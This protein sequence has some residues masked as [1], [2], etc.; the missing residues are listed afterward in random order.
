MYR[1]PYTKGPVVISVGGEYKNYRPNSIVKYH[2]G[3]DLVGQSDKAIVSSVR[4]VAEVNP[5]PESYGYGNHIRIQETGTNRYFLYA[6]LSS[7]VFLSKTEV[8]VG[9]KIGVE[10]N[11]GHSFGSHL[12]LEV[13]LS[14][15]YNDIA[16]PT[17][18]FNFNDFSN[19]LPPVQPEPNA[20]RKAD[21]NPYPEPTRNLKKGDVHEGVKWV[22]WHLQRMGAALIVDGKFEDISDR[23]IRDIQKRNDPPLKADGEVGPLTRNLLACPFIE[24]TVT[25]KQGDK[26][27]GVKWIQWFLNRRGLKPQ[28]IL[29]GEFG[30]Y[31]HGFVVDIQKRYGMVANGI[32]DAKT[33]EKLKVT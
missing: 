9:Q 25:L 8:C 17:K 16:D 27:E 2:R 15:N 13:M 19:V 26:N 31:S 14:N 24:P 30:P 23:W 29:D 20:Q 22:Q 3:V 32:V 21:D 12:H 10:G 18:H 11:T 7:T 5:Y 4:G 6:H 28:L 33:R 1:S